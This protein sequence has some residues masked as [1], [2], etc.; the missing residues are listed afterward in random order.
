MVLVYS[1]FG[2]SVN[3]SY[4]IEGIV[5]DNSLDGQYIY[6]QEVNNN[7]LITLD[8]ALVKDARFNFKGEQPKPVIRELSFHQ[9]PSTQLSPLVFVLQPGNLKAYIDTLSYVTGTDQNDQLRTY[10]DQYYYYKNRISSLITQYQL[11]SLSNEM[12]DSVQVAFQD[13]YDSI[14]TELN[15]LSYDFILLNS[16]SVA[17]SLIFL[18]SYATLTPNQIETILLSAGPEFRSM[19]GVEIVEEQLQREKKAAIGNQYI[20]FTMNNIDG[21][22]VAIS[23]LIGKGRWVLLDFGASSCLPCEQQLPLLK[24]LYNQFHNKGLEIVSISLDNNYEE[25]TQ[26]VKRLQMPWLQ[27]SDLQGW[28]CEAA[29]LYGVQTLP[30]TILINPQGVI[31]ARGIRHQA[32]ATEL[33]KIF[34]PSPAIKK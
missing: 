20:D 4:Q 14:Q 6:L 18:Q 1:M 16:N 21:I 19:H 34:N 22:P 10:F 7:Q 8:S 13:W 27:L 15:K 30:Y 29:L 31:M 9:K 12:T 32:L 11:L 28:D 2:C 5:Q 33:E 3:S 17:G 26:E 25:W 23:S 24:N